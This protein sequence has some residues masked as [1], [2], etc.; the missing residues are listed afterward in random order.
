M[1]TGSFMRGAVLAL[2]A[3]PLLHAQVPAP[4]PAQLD[5]QA[6]VAQ[7]ELDL[8]ALRGLAFQHPVPVAQQTPEEFGRLLDEELREQ[9]PDSK[10]A[11]LGKVVRRL[12]LYRG[13]EIGD[14][15]TLMRTVMTSQAAAYYDSRTRRIFILTG[16]GD[17]LEQGLIYAHELYHGLQDQHFD[18]ESYLPRDDA[19]NADQMLAR[20]AVVEGEATLI[21]TMWV[22]RRMA[23]VDPPRALLA[24]VIGMQAALSMDEMRAMAGMSSPQAAEELDQVPPFILEIMLGNYLKGAAFVFAVQEG[25]WSAVEQL[26]REYPPQSTEQ[27]LHPAKWLARE[28][29]STISWPDLA[30]V[31]ELRD[32]ELLDD[33]VLGEAQWRVVFN[34]QGM[35]AESVA[36]ADGWD[37]DRY[38][39]FKRRNSDATLLLMRTAWDNVAEATQFAGA[40]RRLLA[41]KYDGDTEAVSVEQQGVDVFIVEGGRKADHAAL[42]RVARQASKTRH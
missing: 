7:V 5:L 27:I 39:V 42:L 18:L 40:Y 16:E 28:G 26:Y 4:Q 22:M 12:G 29:P 9:V 14:F 13:P 17:E 20:Q 32:W 23:G 33:D 38:A 30:R 10:A 41:R 1:K 19:L 11:H 34:V 21:H 35:Q 2:L 3:S 31:R 25:G 8:V 24:P 37:G 36:A 6:L 15:R